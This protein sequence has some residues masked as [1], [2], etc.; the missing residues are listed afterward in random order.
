MLEAVLFF[1]GTEQKVL[2]I[3]DNKAAVRIATARYSETANRHMEQRLNDFDVAR[4]IYLLDFGGKLEQEL[5]C[6][7]HQ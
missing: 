1:A 6:C 4:E 7:H 3:C 2:C 5:H